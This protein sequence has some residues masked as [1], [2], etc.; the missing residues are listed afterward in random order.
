MACVG[1]H[2][3][4]CRKRKAGELEAHGVRTTKLC[5]ARLPHMHGEPTKRAWRGPT[6]HDDPTKR[7]WPARHTCMASP[8]NVHGEAQQ[9]MTSPPNVHGQPV[10]HAWRAKQTC[11]A[12]MAHMAATRGITDRQHEGAGAFGA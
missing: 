9:C 7:A 4:R 6:M 10:T 1:A 2:E 8:T 5:M 11:H 12:R 3:R